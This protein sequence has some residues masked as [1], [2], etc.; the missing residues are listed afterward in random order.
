MALPQVIKRL[1]FFARCG[2]NIF[3][4]KKAKRRNHEIKEF[5]EKTHVK[6]KDGC[7]PEHR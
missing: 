7:R 4:K 5:Q 2:I 3:Q 6:Q 1:Q